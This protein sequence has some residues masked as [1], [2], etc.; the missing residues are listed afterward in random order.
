MTT[1]PPAA[2]DAARVLAQASAENFPVA[3]R[4]FPRNVRPHLVNLYGFARFVDD[5]GDE[6][7]G[8]R[9]ALLDWVSS[10]LDLAFGGGEPSHP[11]MRRLA[12]TV[13][14]RALPR[15]PFDRLVEANRQDQ[16]VTRYPTFESLRAY[17]DLS[18]NP[19]GELVL[20]LCGEWTPWR[21]A[22]SDDVCTGL[23]LVEFWQDLGEDA[24][25]GRLYVPLEDLSRFGL[26]DEGLAGYASDPRFAALMRFQAERSRSLL[27][28]GRELARSIGG[29]VG[30]A[31]RLFTA[32]GLAALGD[33]ERRRFDTFGSNAHAAAPRRAWGAARE[34]VRR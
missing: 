31:V 5:V 4:L 22:R 6:A 24:A 25:M 32:G 18:A 1:A 17:C 9:N 10:E 28:R 20:R 11:L 14:G 2:P 19:V 33:L 12:S 13:R 21:G 8:D 26:P 27:I 29:R 15:A 16:R 7:K 23:Q 30:L 34:L 3:S